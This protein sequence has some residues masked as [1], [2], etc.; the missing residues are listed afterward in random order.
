MAFDKF[1]QLGELK[2]MRSQAM[3]LQRQLAAEE[4]VVEEKG[5]RVVITGDQKV[6]ELEVEGVS[7]KIL[8]DVLNQAIKKSQKVAARK[9]QSMGGSLS[10]LM[11]G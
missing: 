7:N 8:V 1:K 11:G 9:L 6:K 5:V 10:S 2:K 3:A 4:V